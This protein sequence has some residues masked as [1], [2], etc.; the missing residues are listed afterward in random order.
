M[1]LGDLLDVEKLRAH[2]HDGDV[3]SRHHE[4]EPLYILNYTTR[5]QFERKWTHETKTCRGLIV[6]DD[7]TIVARPFQK[8]FNLGEHQGEIPLHEPHSIHEKLDGSL[9]IA[10]ARPSDGR[11]SIATRGA[12]HSPQAEHASAWL[13]A[14]HPDWR[15]PAG[16]TWL[17]EIVYPGSRVV[18]DYGQRDE[19]VLLARV[20]IETGKD[21]LDLRGL[22]W[23]GAIAEP[24]TG[25]W[26]ELLAAQ[27]T[28][29]GTGDEGFVVHFHESGLRIKVKT[30]DYARLHRLVCGLSARA[31][32]EVLSTGKS[33]DEFL[34][35]VPDEF[36]EWV[37]ATADRLTTQYRAIERSC[38]DL[39]DEITKATSDRKTLAGI[40]QQRSEH[41]AVCFRML[42]G[43][44]AEQ[45][46]TSYAPLIWKLI[47]PPH[48]TFRTV[49]EDV[50]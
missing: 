45:K 49:S 29:K 7:G 33:L 50:A 1:K 16:E 17:F 26:Q 11:V 38:G 3:K 44:R 2:I 42:G 30:D 32:W 21:L 34:E 22:D 24:F 19:L 10:Y 37:R 25:T 47:Y 5:C 43:Q 40:I 23:P 8:F 35:V 6:H 13:S 31:V 20:G 4:S 14:T 46:Q 15:P 39:V 9:G 41:P 36:M 28:L 18:V 27:K 12:F 48:E